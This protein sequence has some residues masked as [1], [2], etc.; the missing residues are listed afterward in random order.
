MVNV[1]DELNPG[2][3]KG[4]RFQ[5]T[6]SRLRVSSSRRMRASS[7]SNAYLMAGVE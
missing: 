4:G 6:F 5:A 1:L 7:N 2:R 3:T